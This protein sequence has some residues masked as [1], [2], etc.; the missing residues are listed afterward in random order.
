MTNND[1]EAP[2]S[3]LQRTFAPMLSEL[4]DAEVELTRQ[5]AAAVREVQRLDAELERLRTVKKVMMGDTTPKAKRGRPRGEAARVADS[6]EGRAQ[7]EANRERVMEHV[8]D[9]DPGRHFTAAELSR[10]LDMPPQGLGPILTGLERHGMVEVVGM[11][12]GRQ[13]RKRYR[14]VAAGGDG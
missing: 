13:P 1:H 10:V 4:E 6:P 8:R 7:A 9:L 14:R 5:H 2:S 12:D 11:T 3:P